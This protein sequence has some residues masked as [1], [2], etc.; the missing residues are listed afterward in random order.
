MIT[1]IQLKYDRAKNGSFYLPI[2]TY[3]SGYLFNKLSGFDFP[4]AQVDVK[5]RGNYY[6]AQLGNYNYGRRILTVEGEII[7]QNTADFESLRKELLEALAFPN[8]LKDIIITTR[9][10]LELTASVILN[11]R[12][13]IPYQ[14][15]KMVRA[16][17]HFELVAPFPFLLSTTEKMD[18][19]EVY[20]GGGGAVPMGLPF[21]MAAGA[22]NALEIENEG[23]VASF[24]TIRI[25]GAAENPSIQNETTGETLSFTYTLGSDDYIDIDIFNRTAILNG[26]TNIMQYVAGD[27]FKID[28]GVNI[29]KLTGTNTNANAKAEITWRDAYMGI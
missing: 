1:Q 23:N 2:G 19:A 9:E 28:P 6:G 21:A 5:S 20:G 7:A 29:I 12:P 14:K 3:E 18:T 27:W 11:S 16:D 4:E 8:G 15:G 24:P 13:D 22:S 10:G 17:F 25:Y 26:A